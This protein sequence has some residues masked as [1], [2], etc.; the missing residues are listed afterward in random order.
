VEAVIG[1]CR[2]CGRLTDSRVGL[3][4]VCLDCQTERERDP[5]KHAVRRM[6]FAMDRANRNRSLRAAWGKSYH[7]HRTQVEKML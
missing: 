2:R 3:T 7:F 4:P 6:L 5:F 1:D